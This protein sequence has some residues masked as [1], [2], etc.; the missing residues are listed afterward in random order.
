MATEVLILIV[1]RQPGT[2]RKNPEKMKALFEIIFYHM[3]QIDSEIEKDWETPK[4]GF[5]DDFDEDDD[6]ETTRFGI[7]SI[8]RLI[9]SIGEKESL[10]IIS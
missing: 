3:V 8:D 6:F 1:E 5:N 9:S 2:I 10:P 4:E 7:N